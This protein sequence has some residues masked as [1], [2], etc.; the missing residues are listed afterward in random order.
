MESARK[1]TAGHS[2]KERFVAWWEGYELED[3]AQ[4]KGGKPTRSRRSSKPLKD[5]RFTPRVECLNQVWGEGFAAPGDAEFCASLLTP[6]GL[7]GQN[8]VLALAAGLGGP[9]RAVAE[10]FGCW[11]DAMDADPEL[12]EAG[13]ELSDAAGMAK[14]VPVSQF[15]PESSEL[16]ERAYDCVFTRELLHTVADKRSLVGRVEAALKHGGHFL[17]TDYVVGDGRRNSAG[18][19]EWLESEP[20]ERHVSSV[21]ETSNIVVES[22]LEPRVVRNITETYLE[23]ITATWSRWQEIVDAINAFK[24]KREILGHLID[25]VT[26]WTNRAAAIRRGDIQVYSFHATKRRAAQGMSDW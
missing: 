21:Q 5:S 19:K 14:R 24:T 3:V 9:A 6:I 8:K 7:S 1:Q 12:V 16:A 25:E 20:S 18:F 10:A 2:F 17:F 11:V 4:Q 23:H 26:L 15:D 13:M 22:G